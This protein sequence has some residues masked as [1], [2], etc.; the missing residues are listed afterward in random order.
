[1]VLVRIQD[2]AHAL[3]MLKQLQGREHQV[4]TLSGGGENW[5]GVFS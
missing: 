2:A 4:E 3:A 5:L 1:M